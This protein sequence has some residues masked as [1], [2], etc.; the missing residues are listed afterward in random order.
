[1][2]LREG[3]TEN[4]LRNEEEALE[5]RV[6]DS[7]IDAI[8]LDD[9]AQVKTR[10][11]VINGLLMLA[12]F[13]RAGR[14]KHVTPLVDQSRS[15]EVIASQ[16]NL[17]VMA[18]RTNNLPRFIEDPLAG[19]IVVEFYRDNDV[20]YHPTKAWRRGDRDRNGSHAAC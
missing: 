15:V 7:T 1:M 14:I 3:F 2:K 12:L 8:S 20:R 11:G 18:L 16:N 4:S 6:V 5:S 19:M 17:L 10:L 9:V 13:E